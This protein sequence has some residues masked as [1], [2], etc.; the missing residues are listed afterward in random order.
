M[1]MVWKANSDPNQE[2]QLV[3]PTS[4]TN[5][6]ERPAPRSAQTE[7][8]LEIRANQGIE[9]EP[10]SLPEVSP[11]TVP[12]ETPEAIYDNGEHPPIK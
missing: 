6:I 8:S 11:P 9:P 7:D 10:E 2:N 4:L 3:N 12:L 5:N 1:V